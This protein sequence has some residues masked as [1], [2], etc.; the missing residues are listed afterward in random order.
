[1]YGLGTPV[2]NMMIQGGYSISAHARK[3][4]APN[5][6]DRKQRKLK[7]LVKFWYRF[8]DK[9]N[10]TIKEELAKIVNAGS[11]VIHYPDPVTNGVKG[12]M[13]TVN[14]LSQWAKTELKFYL[15]ENVTKDAFEREI[16]E[17]KR[18]QKVYKES[19]SY[20]RNPRQRAVIDPKYFSNYWNDK[21]NQEEALKIRLKRER[22]QWRPY[23]YDPETGIVERNP[24]KQPEYDREIHT[25]DVVN[26]IVSGYLPGQLLE[27]ESDTEVD[28]N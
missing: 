18:N 3:C 19:G 9:S 16:G 17:I 2:H 14:I 27:S 28:S 8:E 21:N 13:Q 15:V 24:E 1:M 20:Y 5:A 7:R 4:V 11:Y 25:G 12:L 26:E 22:E 6:Y 10:E 23:V